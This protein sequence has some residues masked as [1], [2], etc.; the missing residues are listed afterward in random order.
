MVVASEWA[1]KLLSA[2]KF[3]RL[4]AIDALSKQ[5]DQAIATCEMLG[6]MSGIMLRKPN[7]TPAQQQKWRDIMEHATTAG[8]Q[9]RAYGQPK[10]VLTSLSLHL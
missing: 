10:L 2:T 8:D 3:E 9:L 5:R 7:L 4:L 1:R 6:K